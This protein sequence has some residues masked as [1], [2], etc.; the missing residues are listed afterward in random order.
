MHHDTRPKSV[1]DYTTSEQPSDYTNQSSLLDYHRYSNTRKGE[2][3]SCH[4]LQVYRAFLPIVKERCST[5]DTVL[6]T[7]IQIQYIHYHNSTTCYI[8]D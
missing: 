1:T 2:K 5:Q 6:D 7:S 4:E 8:M 3:N